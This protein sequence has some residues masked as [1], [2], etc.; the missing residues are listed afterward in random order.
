MKWYEGNIAEAVTL[1]RKNGSIFVVFVEGLY[2][3]NLL[4]T[5]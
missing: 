5:L 4:S 3:L 2:Y 1:S